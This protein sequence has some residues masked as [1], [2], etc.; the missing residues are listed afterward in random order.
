MPCYCLWQE[1]CVWPF[2]S[3][4]FE[5]TGL[6]SRLKADLGLHIGR[7]CQRDRELAH[8]QLSCLVAWWD[9]RLGKASMHHLLESRAPCRA[10][11]AT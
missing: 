5:A 4:G 11:A 10:L 6:D 8:L 3:A 2:L 7:E 1:C 9:Q